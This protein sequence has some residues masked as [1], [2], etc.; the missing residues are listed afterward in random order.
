MR[1]F[2][3][4]LRR[5][6]VLPLF[7]A[8]ALLTAFPSL[9]G[10]TPS[11]SVSVT[12]SLSTTATNS[13]PSNA[14]SCTKFELQIAGLS[15]GATV[16]V[17]R[18]RDPTG[19]GTLDTTQ[20]LVQSILVTDGQ[21][22]KYGGV[23]DPRIPGDTDGVVDGNITT[24]FSIP[25]QAWPGQFAGSYVLDVVSSTISSGTATASLTITQ[26]VTTQSISGQITSGGNPV[27]H[28]AMML[29]D[30]NSHGPGFICGVVADA[31]GHYTIQAPAGSY[32]IYAGAP[33]FV[34]PSPFPLPA[35]GAG[36]SLTGQNISLTAAT[37][38]ITSQVKATDGT[39]IVPGVQFYVMSNNANL[40]SFAYSD[41]SGNVVIPATV[42][43]DWSYQVDEN[44]LDS[45]GYLP[46]Q[47]GSGPADT[48]AGSL[49][50]SSANF[51]QFTPANA[52]IYG[53]LKDGSGNPLAGV[54]VNDSDTTTTTF[55]DDFITNSSGQFFLLAASPPA[56]WQL[57]V[58]NHSLA[59]LGSYLAPSNVNLTVAAN[60]AY[61]ET[62]TASLATSYFTGTVRNGSNGNSPVA[63]VVID[64]QPQNGGN[65]IS[66]TTDS[67]GNF[68]LGVTP[69]VWNIFLD[70][71]SA[72]QNNLIGA[73]LTETVSSN[74][75]IS[76]L[77]YTVLNANAVV[78]G[79]AKDGNGNP[80]SNNDNV[81]VTG[82]VSSVQYNLYVNLD[83]NGNYS[84]PL[85]NGVW[86]FGVSGQNGSLAGFLPVTVTVSNNQSQTVN[87]APAAASA[88]FS[89][90]V[91]NGSTPLIGAIIDAQPQNNNG[92]GNSPLF[93]A[94]TDSNG[95]FSLGVTSGSW[96]LYLD[97]NSVNNLVVPQLTETI[98]TG[99]TLPVGTYPV[100]TATAN[101]SGTVKDANGTS[102]PTS[103]NVFATATISNLQYQANSNVSGGGT[104]SLPLVNGVWSLSV[105]GPNGTPPGFQNTTVTVSNNQNQ[106]VNLAPLV[107]TATFSGS[108]TNNGSPVSGIT[109]DAQ[110]QN[111]SLFL[112]TT[113]SVNGSF[114]L[115]VQA[116]T[117]NVSV[118]GPIATQLN[119]VV[120]GSLNETITTSQTIPL[121]AIPVL[122][123]TATVS[124]TVRDANGAPLSSAFNVAATATISG[125]QYNEDVN[126]DNNGDGGY[127]LPLVG[128]VWQ[129]NV[130]G[131][132]GPAANFQSTTV[133]V[134]NNQN[135]TV[136]LA[137]PAATA[138][139]TG[140]V[141][142]GVVPVSGITVFASLQGNPGN[143]T[144]FQATTDSGGNF[145]LGVTTGSWNIFLDNNALT[146]QNL[147]ASNLS[148]QNIATSQTLSGLQLQVLTAT[149]T[150]TGS[151]SDYSGNLV[152]GNF[153]NLNGTA[154]ISGVG[155][156]TDVSTTNGGT[157]S[158]PV[159]NGTWNV[160]AGGGGLNF[161]GQTA[162]V[163][164]SAT[165][166]FVASAFN[167]QP[168]NQTI[169]AGQNTSFFV[170]PNTP[171]TANLQWQVST[172]GGNNWTNLS[173]NTT[174]TGSLTN[175]L[176][177]S[178]A[179]TALNGALYRCVASFT[180]NSSPVSQPSNP[181]SLTVLSNFAS[182]LAQFFPGQAS[183]PLITG[184]NA[185]PAGDGMP[186]LMKYA[187]G[188]DP[189]KVDAAMG[190][191]VV[192]KS[193]GGNLTITYITP[194]GLTDITY[195]VEVSSDL[196][197]WSSG[198]SATATVSSTN[199]NQQQVQIVIRDLTPVSGTARR[200]IRLRV[201]QP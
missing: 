84:V 140:T 81:S 127:S 193:G 14:P 94:T 189:T 186:N 52:L 113:T 43:T 72:T 63:G 153:V 182:Y 65:N 58:D 32:G 57:Q 15:V 171:G 107:A 41:T 90:T 128:G 89:G 33:G 146:Q 196:V 103:D 133:T 78:S 111:G 110:Q 53:T 137:P 73:Q 56:G 40:F 194:P 154:T 34:G 201:T 124:G 198:P 191:P 151:V 26:P 20:P 85:L 21:V 23:T 175:G 28:A 50:F 92:G 97:S 130:Y 8:A 27:P 49:T 167:T 168:Q 30:T 91:L 145:N 200:F 64:V 118:D 60:T 170:G 44:S 51:G 163:S 83:N 152:N 157:Y 93:Q 98:S 135:Q 197:N 12:T 70:G 6:L 42:A 77:T 136:N 69:G 178:N 160:S 144:Q 47:N 67:N 185:N 159:V 68:S 129:F 62:L 150:I 54:D 86:T 38:T 102:L 74:Q 116:G 66:A 183:N 195:I 134:S 123:A 125:V 13:L 16:R 2:N 143:N 169:T 100:L 176:T 112:Q 142:N 188:L 108:V 165:L 80:L 1:T 104:Y 19:T 114:T 164:G 147:I 39:T 161:N 139:F 46:L 181:A 172:N 184:P 180:V 88:T 132:G 190:A 79:T 122:T 138:H 96:N 177:V 36:A 82:T 29:L 187:L 162:T 105:G 31:T 48:T 174:Y 117:W 5:G 17:N 166:N 87:L 120:P 156:V 141:K 155:Y 3:P 121:G 25:S 101:V 173:D 76:G 4:S 131:P 119:L 45:I 192:G 75:T 37:R 22:T 59:A 9:A 95:H 199:L 149:G 7:A 61:A 158:L 71:D 106:T 126:L 148:N 179:P 24:K 35:L 55:N 99:Q 11:V 109:V 115:G 18:Y 10:A